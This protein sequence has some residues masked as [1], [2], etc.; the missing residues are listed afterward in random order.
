[1]ICAPAPAG[2]GRPA[3]GGGVQLGPEWQ[4]YNLQ[5]A[6][7]PFDAARELAEGLPPSLL[8][9]D[10]RMELAVQACARAAKM[11]SENLKST[12]SEFLAKVPRRIPAAAAAHCL[13]RYADARTSRLLKW[14]YCLV[15]HLATG[16]SE[17]LARAIALMLQSADGTADDRR[18]SSY[19]ITAYNLDR[20]YGC[21]LRD[22]VLAS[23]L[24]FIRGRPHNVFTYKCAHVIA[25]LARDSS[26]LD[27]MLDAMIWAAHVADG[28]DA[29]HC[30]RAAS[31]LA[32]VTRERAACPPLP[33]RRWAAP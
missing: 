9:P 30:L 12:E 10:R 7:E 24:R 33:P 27:E 2:G 5:E 4:R 26:T 15:L 19:I 29:I 28:L 14:H 31:L 16:R 13:S 23:A 20:W 25:N 17:W 1:M 22:A 21:G 8:D 18:A 3:F 6:K 11:Y 32:G